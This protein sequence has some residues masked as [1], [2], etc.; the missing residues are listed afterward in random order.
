MKTITNYKNFDIKISKLGNYFAYS[1]VNLSEYVKVKLGKS[2]SIED[3]KSSID[4]FWKRFNNRVDET[5][6]T[7]RKK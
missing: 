2:V 7:R 6:K 1:D 4:N 5:L 3:A